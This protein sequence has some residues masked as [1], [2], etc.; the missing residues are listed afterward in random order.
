MT[1]EEIYQLIYTHDTIYLPPHEEGSAPLEVALGCS[2][3]KCTFC[4]FTKDKFQI[5]PL[6]R[7]EQNIQILGLLQP[8][9]PRLFFL[10]ENA[11]CMSTD[12][13]LKILDLKDKYMSNVTSFAMYSRIDD[14]ARK[15]DEDLHLLKSKGLSALHIGIESGC[16]KLLKLRNKGI[17]S[18]DMIRELHRLDAAGI[19]YFVTIIPGLGGRS[20]SNEHAIETAQLLNQV[21]PQNIWCLKLKLWEGTTLY[22]EWENGYFDMMTPEEIILEERLMIEHLNLENCLFEDTTVLDNYTIRGILPRQKQDLLNA[23]DYLLTVRP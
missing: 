15:S 20:L 2:W 9:N 11:F 16:D 5:H 4:D 13:I 14:I 1:R 3:G 12:Y 22:K 17:T 21:R 18:D 23:I 7:I 19:M 10:G 8:D 6:E